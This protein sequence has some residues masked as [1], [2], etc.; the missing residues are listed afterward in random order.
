MFTD[1]AF[2]KSRWRVVAKG[3]LVLIAGGVAIYC[4][5]RWGDGGLSRLSAFVASH[6]PVGVIC[7]IVINAGATMVC[8]PQVAFTVMAG[9]LFGWKL[10]TAWASLG[11]TIGAVGAF[12]IARYGVR[13]R[14]RNRFEHRG[15]FRNMQRLSRNH[16][17]KVIA[18][19]RIIPVIPFPLASYM[20][21]V[22]EIHPWPYAVLT[23]ACMLPETVFLASGGHL[24]HSGITGRASLEAAVVL[25]G[26]A[27]GLGAAIHLIRKRI[28]E[29][30]G[31]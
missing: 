16:P 6:G 13:E 9:A 12:C 2:G 19:T 25:G 3:V 7:F 5:E 29:S 10:G 28:V 31:G 18:V 14:L 20:L 4:A 21:G 1:D 8:F 15:A 11:M 23:W 17:L 22:T 27:L 26:A 24:L 30:N